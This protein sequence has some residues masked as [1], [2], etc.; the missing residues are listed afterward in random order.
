M[1]L[2]GKKDRSLSKLVYGDSSIG[3]KEGSEGSLQPQRKGI[4]EMQE[5]LN[6]IFKYQKTSDFKNK[7][8][9]G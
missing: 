5:H 1:A 9:G 3:R 8:I 6:F 2:L 4:C 7:H